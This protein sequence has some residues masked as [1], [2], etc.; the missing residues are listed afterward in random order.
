MRAWKKKVLKIKPTIVA[1]TKFIAPAKPPVS[2]STSKRLFLFLS[3]TSIVV[4]AAI[5]IA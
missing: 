5:Q 3:Y 2:A 4:G 1:D